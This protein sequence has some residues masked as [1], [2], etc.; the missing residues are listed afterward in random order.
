MAKR[1][2][3]YLRVPRRIKKYL[4]D[5]T[6]LYKVPE[7]EVTTIIENEIVLTEEDRITRIRSI[8]EDRKTKE[9]VNV[10]YD[11][12]IGEKW[13]TIVRYDSFHGY[14]HRHMLVS[15]QVRIDTPST[16]GVI[17][18]GDPDKWY[19]WAISDIQKRYLNYKKGFMRRSKITNM[20]Y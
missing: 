14:L 9:V 19:T 12:K 7:E 4:D 1:S 20:G 16:A 11:I 10:S 6:A 8:K 18:K 3:N 13:E 5:L 15:L 17:K 2:H